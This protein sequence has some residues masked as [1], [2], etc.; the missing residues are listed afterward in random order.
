MEYG[1]IKYIRIIQDKYRRL[2]NVG[3]VSSETK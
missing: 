1:K 3:M 2:G